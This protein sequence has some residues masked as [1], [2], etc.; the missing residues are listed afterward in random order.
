M[1]LHYVLVTVN[2]AYYIEPS[3]SVLH[4]KSPAKHR[5]G[6]HRSKCYRKERHKKIELAKL[7]AKWPRREISE[8]SRTSKCSVQSQTHLLKFHSVHKLPLSI[9]K[10]YLESELTV[11]IS[12]S[13]R[14]SSAANLS[15]SKQ[16][17]L[18]TSQKA[19]YKARLLSP[20][21][22]SSQHKVSPLFSNN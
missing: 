13:P 14:H 12:K 20:S 8:R 1:A 7:P 9:P 22:A 2:D 16:C 19:R 17:S 11:W 18:V 15:T 6:R 21:K 3:P 5:I 4:L 10:S